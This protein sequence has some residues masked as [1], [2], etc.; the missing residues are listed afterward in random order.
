MKLKNKNHDKPFKA[1]FKE[2]K[3]GKNRK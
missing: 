1:G 2:L 3:G